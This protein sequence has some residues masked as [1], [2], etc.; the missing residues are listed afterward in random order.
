VGHNGAGKTSLLNLLAATE[1]PDDGEISRLRGLTVGMVEQFVPQPLL[2]LPVLEAVLTTLPEDQRS[3]EAHRAEA[4]LEQLGLLDHQKPVA[5]L[6][7]G[8]QNLVLFIRASLHEPDLLLMD[9]PGNHMDV[10][11]LSFFTQ[12]LQTTRNL[13]YLMISHDRELLDT[14]CNR[15]VFL[16]DQRLRS[17]DLPFSAARER[18]LEQDAQDEH[19]LAV[20]TKEINRIRVSAKRI[21]EWGRI[22][23]NE[24]LAR[25]ARNM[26]ARADKLDANKT[27]VT[28][29]SG[30]QLSL[31]AAGLR[32]K[33]V[34]TLENLSVHTPDEARQLLH[35]E[36]LVLQPGDRVAL[37]GVNGSGKSTTIER[38][39]AALGTEQQDVR[40]NPNVTLGY[41]DQE[42]RDFPT[43][44]TRLDWLRQRVTVG[45]G[46]IKR[47]LLHA[48]IAYKDF[49]QAVDTLSG[50]EKARMVFMQLSLAKPTLLILDEPTNHIDL[51]SRL[52][53]ETQL[54]STDGS[55]LVTS[56]DR[57]FLETVCNR[58]W[59]IADGKL[60]EVEHLAQ[61]YEQ[62]AQLTNVADQ[63]Q[64]QLR[65]SP[66]A[67]DEQSLYDRLQ[68]LEDLL[69]ADQAR[70]P[71]F[72]K[73]KLQAEWQREIDALWQKLES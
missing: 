20:E 33:T 48:G 19:R 73:P 55:M 72:Q 62:L 52:E 1:Q 11:T 27:E 7:G 56:H 69:A 39:R 41:F 65:E 51:E 23:D 10:M 2:P 50:G 60:R 42:L 71:K 70:K 32:S 30:L 58:F 59:L 28:A 43:G 15:T 8:Q 25:K 36:L 37:L 63:D 21:G 29:G 17:F 57:Q 49:D 64:A 53:L 9:E 3:S 18:L 67:D 26:Q 34:V 44:Q 35:C 45:D 14:C 13:T 16:R 46:P 22:H 5:E 6:S 47:A 61:Y 68:E 54:Q 4:A 38:I 31:D 40:F 24:K 66:S 12:Y